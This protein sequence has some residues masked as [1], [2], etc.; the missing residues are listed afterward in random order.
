MFLV[1]GPQSVREALALPDLVTAVF[2]TESMV[3][4][5]AALVETAV[6]AGISPVLVPDRDLATFSETVTPPGIVAICHSVDVALND[7]LAGPPQLVLCCA[8]VRDPGNAG[9]VIR[10]ADAFGADAVLLTEGSVDAYNAKTVRASAGSIFHVP[11]VLGVGLAAALD[12]CRHRGLQVLA[13]DGAGDS[14]LAVLATAGDLDRP[15]VWLFGNESW[16]LPEEQLGLADRVVRVPLYGAAESLNLSTAAAV[17]L[18]A[19][20]SAQRSRRR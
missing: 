4:R 9:T 6:A 3:D 19:T 5:H 18:Y 11:L 8:Q 2:V 10:C 7:A 15:T 1:E 17:C 16:G 12:A 13:A 20:A 14:D